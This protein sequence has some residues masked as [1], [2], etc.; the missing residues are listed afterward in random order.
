MAGEFRIWVLDDSGDITPVKQTSATEYEDDLEAALVKNPEMLM[1]GLELVGRQ[2]PV[3]GGNLDLLGVDRDGRLVVFELKRGALSRA[4]VTQVIDYCSSLESMTDEDLA[5][6]IA[7]RSGNRGIGA[8]ED[9]EEWYDQRFEKQIESLRPVRMALVGLGADDSAIRMV[10]YLRNQGVGI[11]L[12]TFFGYQHN[13]QVL[14]A[15]HMEDRVARDIDARTPAMGPTAKEKMDALDQLASTLGIALLW[16]QMKKALRPPP[17]HTYP[18]APRKKSITFSHRTQLPMDELVG[19]SGAKGS[20][21]IG[22]ETDGQVRVTFYPVSIEICFEE[23]TATREQ[24]PFQFETPPNAPATH[25]VPEQWYCVL[26]ADGWAAHGD[27]LVGL[28]EAVYREWDKRLAA[29]Q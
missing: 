19:A 9:F 25:R 13:G 18:Y 20:H 3:A 24:M 26:D 10:D 1:P 7:E 6:H 5:L 28:V 17:T 11:T 23:F 27:A 4:A 22:M 8:I 12:M 16:Q 14:L 15:R 21:S 2:T 29:T